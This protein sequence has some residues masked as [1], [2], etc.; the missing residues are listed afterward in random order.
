MPR[1]C[2]LRHI[3]VSPCAVYFKPAGIPVHLL[4]EVVL[5]LDELEALRLADLE[6]L[7]QEQASEKMKI[8]R[9]TFSRVIEQARRKVA[10][11]LIH[12]KAL[13]LEG[14]AVVIKGEQKMPGK[15]GTGP[16]GG[17]RGKGRGSC[18]CGQWRGAQ[19]AGGVGLSPR[20]RR[21]RGMACAIAS[22]TETIATLG[23]DAGKGKAEA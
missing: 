18:G 12:G 23:K 13:R 15:D 9:P 8:S 6:G 5:A 22:P 16:M 19:K 11:A 20:G 7:Y 4:E 2:C 21:Q 3:D 14:G 1:P 17:G 10:D